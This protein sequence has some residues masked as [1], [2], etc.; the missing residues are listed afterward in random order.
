MGH[1]WETSDL[2]LFLDQHDCFDYWL[3]FCLLLG[4]EGKR[5]ERCLGRRL[6]TAQDTTAGWHIRWKV[7]ELM[8]LRNEVGHVLKQEPATLIPYVCMYCLDDSST[9]NTLVTNLCM[10]LEAVTPADASA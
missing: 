8:K 5:P 3:Y 6:I 1:E 7:A 9:M 10:L 2:P 4:L